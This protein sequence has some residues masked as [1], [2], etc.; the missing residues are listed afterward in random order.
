MYNQLKVRIIVFS[1]P[2]HKLF[3]KNP[4]PETPPCFFGGPELTNQPLALLELVRRGVLSW[5]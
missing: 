4:Y 1:L 3:F 5:L 2:L